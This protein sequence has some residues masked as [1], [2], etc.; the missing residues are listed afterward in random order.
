MPG[1]GKAVIGSN[2]GVI[3][4]VAGDFASASSAGNAGGPEKNAKGYEIH[5]G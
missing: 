2:S 1:I 5:C 3:C 4:I